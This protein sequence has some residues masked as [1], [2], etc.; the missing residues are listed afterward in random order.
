MKAEVVTLLSTIMKAEVGRVESAISPLYKWQI[1]KN[2]S[3]GML[4]CE[5]PYR[6]YTVTFIPSDRHC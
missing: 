3:G 2:V 5:L 1:I 6:A 4:A